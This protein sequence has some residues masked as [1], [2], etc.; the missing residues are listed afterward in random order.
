MA[1]FHAGAKRPRDD[2]LSNDFFSVRGPSA[3]ESVLVYR[4]KEGKERLW[5]SF[6]AAGGVVDYRENGSKETYSF[7]D[8]R[9][10]HF[11][12]GKKVEYKTKTVHPDGTTVLFNGYKRGSEAKRVVIIPRLGEEQCY[13]GNKGQETKRL[14]YWQ[15]SR[16]APQAG[17]CFTIYRGAQGA[18]KRA[19]SVMPNGNVFHYQGVE[20]DDGEYDDYVSACTYPDDGRTCFFSRTATAT[21]AREIS[22]TINASGERDNAASSIVYDRLD[23]AFKGMMDKMLELKEAGHCKEQAVLE[24]GQQLKDAHASLVAYRSLAEGIEPGA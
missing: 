4:G 1:T 11:A 14:A 13:V 9:V 18:E 12:G 22:R 7:P 17:P 2:D 8:G 21:G 19:L 6:D 15:P 10:Q 5:S 23:N 16:Y 20:N 24:M 3:N